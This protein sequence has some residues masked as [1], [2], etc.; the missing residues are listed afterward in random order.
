MS[1][2]TMYR[3]VATLVCAVDTVLVIVLAIAA[4]ALMGA[5]SHGLPHAAAESEFAAGMMLGGLALLAMVLAVGFA[6]HGYWCW[7]RIRKYAPR[8][9]PRWGEIVLLLFAPITALIVVAAVALWLLK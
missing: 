9:F 5:V 7:R 2:A 4:A 6:L 1:D 3:R 8:Q